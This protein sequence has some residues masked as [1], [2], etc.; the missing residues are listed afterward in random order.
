MP[1]YKI[2][3]SGSQDH[4]TAA[5]GAM[6]QVYESSRHIKQAASPLYSRADLESFA[7]PRDHFLS[8]LITLGAYERYGENRNYDGFPHEQLL[9]KH[10]TFETHARNYREHDNKDPK[11]AVGHIKS[12]R[13]CPTLQRGELLMWTKIAS[14]PR[15]FEKAR[16]GEEQSGSMA[17]KVREDVCGVCDFVSKKPKDRCDCIRYTPG[18]YFPEKRAY[19]IMLNYDPTFVDYSWVRRPA[20]RIA[21]HLNY[22]MPEHLK[23][24]AESRNLRGDELAEMYG[25][26]SDTDLETLRAI[27]AAGSPDQG[28]DPFKYAFVVNVAPYA[29]TEHLDEPTLEKM[30]AKDTG[31]VM[32][33]LV[34]RQM[35]LP[36]ADF[37]SWMTGKSLCTSL[38]DSIVK[39]ASQ[40]MASIRMVIIK[41]LGEDPEFRT[42][43]DDSL[44]EMSPALPGFGCGAGDAVAGFFDK[45]RDKFSTRYEVLQK[46]ASH[47]IMS[48]YASIIDP[49]APSA[50]AQALGALYNAYLVKTA[51]HL[52][53]SFETHSVLAAMR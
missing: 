41:R 5:V 35:V 27:D 38:N 18:R 3:Q 7:P 52:P 46:N 34:D 53:N 49:T 50:E 37:H 12:A 25:L 21:H 2:I 13:Y 39:E 44:R 11:K 22:L 45:V 23:A 14:A 32:R 15:E 24:A 31:K 1:H 33:E 30:A 42:L 10:A 51:A 40:K 43:F 28:G 16:K 17:A 36:L 47:S 9:A 6:I 8:H 29:I 4:L 19:A 20:D 48:G 26:V